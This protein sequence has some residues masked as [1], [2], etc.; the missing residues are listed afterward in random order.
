MGRDLLEKQIKAQGYMGKREIGFDS[1]T[2]GRLHGGEN[3]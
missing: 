2:L 3:I 1:G